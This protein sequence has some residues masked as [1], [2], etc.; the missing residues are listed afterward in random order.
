MGFGYIISW[1]FAYVIIMS[2]CSLLHG[3]MVLAWFK[4]L[5][6]FGADKI[7]VSDVGVII[8]FLWTSFLLTH[9]LLLYFPVEM[10]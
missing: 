4:V 3:L 2:V 1:I 8:A 9:I 7:K 10:Q 5:Y 6:W